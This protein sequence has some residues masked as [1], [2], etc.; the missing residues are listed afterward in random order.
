M[1]QAGVSIRRVEDISKALWGTKVSPVVSIVL[2][3]YI[4]GSELLGCG[5]LPNGLSINR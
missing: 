2:R 3:K 1:H 5:V 4:S